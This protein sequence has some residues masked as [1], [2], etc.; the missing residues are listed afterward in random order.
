MLIKLLIDYLPIFIYVTA[1]SLQVSGALLICFNSVSLKRE[2]IVK[3]FF[4]LKLTS[5][6]DDANK[7]TY[8]EQEFIN[9]FKNAYLMKWSMIY[10]AIGY[11][12]S[13]F[14]DISSCTE[15]V[16]YLV[17]LFELLM[18]II[19]MGITYFIINLFVQNNKEIQ[20]KVTNEEL[21]EYGIEVDVEEM[22]SKQ[23]DSYFQ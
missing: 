2:N 23:I 8:N 18:T 17:F 15:E 20:K 9:Q 14:G 10:I 7:I 5:K 12:F 1:N 21:I 6:E 11:A 19:V 4:K 3:D 13:I 22:S 16:K